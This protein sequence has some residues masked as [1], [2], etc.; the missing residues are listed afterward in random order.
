M[1]AKAT[2]AIDFSEGDIIDKPALRDLIRSAV[3]F[4]LSGGTRK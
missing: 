2:R 4:N 1:N 3:A